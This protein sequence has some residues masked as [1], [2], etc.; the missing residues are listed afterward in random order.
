MADG[1]RLRVLTIIDDFTRECLAIEV[2]GSMAGQ[3]VARVLDRVALGRG[4]PKAVTVDN[5][6]EFA[7]R[8]LD[9]WAYGHAVKLNFIQPGKPVQNAYI[10]RFNGRLRD[11]CLDVHWFLSRDHARRTIEEWRADYNQV[12]P[13][14]ALGRRPP[15]EYGRTF[16]SSGELFPLG[17]VS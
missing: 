13:H 11:E 5:G 3:G 2:D 7:R 6:P 10:D 14:S 1:R 12:R 16:T 17:Q 9:A 8:A 4:Y 15:A